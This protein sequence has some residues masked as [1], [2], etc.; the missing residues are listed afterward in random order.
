MREL[1]VLLGMGGQR[2]AQVRQGVNRRALL[3][4]QQGKRKQQKQQKSWPGFHGVLTLHHFFCCDNDL[5]DSRI[6]DRPG[7]PF[8]RNLARHG[9]YY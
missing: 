5:Y 1:L 8:Q 2:F 7:A 3:S 6:C 9:L 4:K